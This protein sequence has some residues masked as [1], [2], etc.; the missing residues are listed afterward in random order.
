[1]RRAASLFGARLVQ[2][3]QADGG[4][5]APPPWAPGTA[6]GEALVGEIATLLAEVHPDVV[7]TFD[8]RHGSTCHPDHRAVAALVL[9]AQ[10]QAASHPPVFLLETVVSGVT[11][12]FTTALAPGA[13]FSAG[14][15]GFDATV[16]LRT[17]PVT[18][19]QYLV[20][21]A[22]AHPSQFVPSAVRGLARL[23]V[24]QRAVYIAPAALALA[25]AGVATC[26]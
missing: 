14:T 6:A 9:A 8:P 4:G 13:P 10:Q 20:W 18:A 19:W 1:M 24:S 16:T 12:P 3:Q 5:A 21:T 25:S 11:Q 7:L 2:W 17:Q 22:Q 26:P 23:P 15:T